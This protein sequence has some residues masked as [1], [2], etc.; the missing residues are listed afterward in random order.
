MARTIKSLL[1]IYTISAAVGLVAVFLIVLFTSPQNSIAPLIGM[2][3]AI[4]FLAFGV[5]GLLGIIIRYVFI[6]RIAVFQNSLVIVRQSSWIGCIASL[7]LF[8][9][10]R[11]L[12]NIFTAILLV[13]VFATLEFLLLNKNKPQ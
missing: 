5:A 2:F 11:Q 13:A 6:S 8:F 4:F 12:L 10:S 1:S 7:A 9:N 3:T